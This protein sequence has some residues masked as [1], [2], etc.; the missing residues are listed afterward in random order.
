ML[1]LPHT[2]VQLMSVSNLFRRDIMLFKSLYL[3]YSQIAYP[4]IDGKLSHNGG[5]H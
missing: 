1:E 2:V 3:K 5:T 4:E